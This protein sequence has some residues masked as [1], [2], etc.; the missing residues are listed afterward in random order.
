M[1]TPI[2]HLLKLR[3]GELVDAQ[4]VRH[5]ASCSICTAELARL[6]RVQQRMQLLAAA[7]PPAAAWEQIQA[8]VQSRA[9]PRH[10][11]IAVAIAA[12]AVVAVVSGLLMRQVDPAQRDALPAIAA[13]QESTAT[14]P[15]EHLVAQS[16]ELD[17]LL[18][19]L[20]GRP[21]VERVSMAATLDTIESRVQWLDQQL[22]Y[23]PD[24]GLNDAQTYQLWRERVDLM[25]SLVK[26]RY[27]EGGHLSF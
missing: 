5:L 17:E 6:R 12:A 14:V 10:G 18:H 16:R 20:P 1:H 9:N 25:D 19:Y 27:A 13:T 15:L 4:Q 21:A 23:A 11:R 26:V 8:R 22:S 3:D 24:S 7:D 2:D